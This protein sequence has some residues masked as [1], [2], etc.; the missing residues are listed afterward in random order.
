[1]SLPPSRDLRRLPSGAFI[2]LAAIAYYRLNLDGTGAV[3]GGTGYTQGGAAFT[4][5]STADARAINQAL[6]A[7]ARP[8]ADR[9]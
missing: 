3:T 9:A 6:S 1:M 2:D 5:S 4:I 7:S 8:L